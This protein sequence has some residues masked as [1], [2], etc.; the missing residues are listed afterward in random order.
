VDVVEINSTFYRPAR[1]RVAATWVQRTAAFADFVF[2]AKVHRS[3]TH[4]S[5]T[6]EDAL[7]PTLAGLA[8]LREAGRLA[9]LLLQFPQ[10][11][12]FVPRS[13][14][15]IAALL[16]SLAGWPAV[17]EVRHAS[18]AADAAADW[19]VRHGLGWCAVDQP[20]A[21]SAVLALLPRVTGPVGYLR[22]HG[23]NAADWF[24]AD[25]GRDARYDYLYDARQLR[26]IAERARAMAAQ[27]AELVVVQNNH[28][29]GQALVNALQMK[30][31]L[32]GVRPAAPARLVAAYPALAPIVQL[33]DARLF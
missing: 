2:T 14:D 5:A 7:G 28:F 18:W 29:R 26:E 33:E 10:T 11:F 30:A 15:R 24:R 16:E 21:G 3:C 17:V 19:F 12:R 4:E 31:L 8:P 22:L 9:A 27:A 23:R 1:A 25:A 20:R 13:L 32:Q 6:P